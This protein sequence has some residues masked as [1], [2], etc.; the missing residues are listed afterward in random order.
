MVTC[1][2]N[3]VFAVAGAPLNVNVEST[4]MV[5]VFSPLVTSI[6]SAPMA[7]AV[8]IFAPSV[9]TMPL[10]VGAVTV[11]DVAKTGEPVPVAVT[12]C[13]VVAFVQTAT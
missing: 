1:T 13:T 3:Q 2:E 12:P 11:G 5:F 6:A 4:A 10:N 8:V 9:V 7:A